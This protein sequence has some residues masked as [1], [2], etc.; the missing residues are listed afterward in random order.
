MDI[1]K[2]QDLAHQHVCE[3]T[4]GGGDHL[5]V[6]GAHVHEVVTLFTCTLCTISRVTYC[7]LDRHIMIRKSRWFSIILM[8]RH[9]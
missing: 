7:E 9:L 2:Q 1:P 6:Q 4:D 8:L 3:L 5:I